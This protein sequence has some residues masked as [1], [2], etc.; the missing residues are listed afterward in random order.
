MNLMM[1]AKR[2]VLVLSEDDDGGYVYG[3]LVGCEKLCIRAQGFTYSGSMS[4]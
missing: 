3:V 2:L 4:H 1:N